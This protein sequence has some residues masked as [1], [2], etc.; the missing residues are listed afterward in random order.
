MKI[1]MSL[2][3]VKR[4]GTLIFLLVFLLVSEIMSASV[5]VLSKSSDDNLKLLNNIQQQLKN[6]A[7][8][9]QE[10][11]RD[12]SKFKKDYEKLNEQFSKELS[13]KEGLKFV[14]AAEGG[15]SNDKGDKGGLTNLGITHSEYKIYR[16]RKGLPLRSVKEISLLEASDIYKHK[17]W[18]N[19][20][21]ADTPRRIAI[22]CFDWDVNSG[23]GFFTLQQALGGIAIDGM[24]GPETFNELTSWLS[25]PTNEDKLLHKY[26][27][28]RRADYRRWGVGSQAIFLQGWLRRAEM[29]K[30]YLN[31]S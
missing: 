13:F 11:S 8:E 14:L 27:E 25:K 16:A 17:Y 18:I 9:L 10:V 31:V 6:Q 24:P 23:R 3:N 19:S 30:S 21:C 12:V 28:I 4:Q 5:I 15:V 20:G 7:K 22:S 1:N 29:L 2:F 26:F